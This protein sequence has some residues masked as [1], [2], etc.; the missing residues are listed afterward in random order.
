MT[1]ANQRIHVWKNEGWVKSIY[2]G[3]TVYMVGDR[4]VASNK[5]SPC[6]RLTPT[7]ILPILLKYVFES[8]DFIALL[9]NI[10]EGPERQM[11]PRRSVYEYNN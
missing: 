11:A 1:A 5:V 8:G 10:T 2:G 7:K 3:S 4:A 6:P 9:S